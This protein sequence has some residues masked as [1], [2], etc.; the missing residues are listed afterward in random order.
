MGDTNNVLHSSV[1]NILCPLW[2]LSLAEKSCKSRQQPRAKFPDYVISY[3]FVQGNHWPA[4]LPQYILF[5]SMY[6]YIYIY[7][8]MY[9]YIYIYIYIYKHKKVYSVTSKPSRR[10]IAV[11]DAFR[12]LRTRQCYWTSKSWT[13]QMWSLSNH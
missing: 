12:P 4:F 10:R 5:T 8:Y 7:I 11:A 13:C 1:K 6:I 3:D 2:N 9:I